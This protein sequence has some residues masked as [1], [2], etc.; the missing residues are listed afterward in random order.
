MFGLRILG[1]FALLAPLISGAPN[2][3]LRECCEVLPGVDPGC[4]RKYCDFHN[5]NSLMVVPFITECGPKGS[6]AGQVWKCLSSKHDHTECCRRQGVLPFCVPF[7]KADT[8]VPTDL[9]KY[10]ICINEFEKYRKCFRTYIQHNGA[11][12]ENYDY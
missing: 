12:H 11:Y 4:A 10:A 5:V 9:P 7:C 6:T 1:L 3:K 8:A 2:D